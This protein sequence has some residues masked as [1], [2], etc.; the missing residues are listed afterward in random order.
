MYKTIQASWTKDQ[1][2]PERAFRLSMLNRV[3]DGTLY[4]CLKHPFHEEKNASQEYIPLRQRRPSVRYRLCRLVVDDSV[5][6]LFSEGH[7]PSFE[8]ENENAKEAL[9]TLCKELSLNELLID[10]ATRGSV[11][12]VAILLR[13]LDS[14]AFLSVHAT[15]YLTPTWMKDAPDTLE[16]VTELYKVKGKQLKDAGYDVDSDEAMFW[17]QRDWTSDQEVWYVPL[18]D[19]DRK[20]GK[21]PL[22]DELRSVAHKLGFVPIVWIKNLPGGDDIDGACTFPNEAIDTAIEIDYQLSQAGRGLKYTSDPT[23]LI[24]EPA[25]GDAGSMVKGAGNAIVVSAEGDAKMLEINGTA[26]EAVIAYVRLLRELAVES[27]H[28]NRAS[29]DKMTAAQSGRALEL[30]NQALIWL[31]DKLRISYGEGAL[32]NLLQMLMRA[33]A[34]VPLK[35]RDGTKLPEIVPTTKISLRWPDWYAPT[36]QD[37]LDRATTLRTLCD[38]GLLSRETAIKILSA[39]YDIKDPIAEKMLA[40]VDMQERNEAAQKKVAINE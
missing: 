35:L 37:M 7:F 29:A 6:L 5:S 4:D 33:H 24:K 14:R 16:K 8:C 18:K 31:A 10:A 15:T 32:L 23:L 17:F 34:K 2:L 12:S 20:D 25:G 13:V 26:V 3:L 36:R 38:A 21:Q 30:M 9:Q 39:E 11:G 19:S 22:I 27:M 28:G 1:D 40:D